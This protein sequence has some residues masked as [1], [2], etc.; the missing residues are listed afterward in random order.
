[1]CIVDSYESTKIS[2]CHQSS[3][4]HSSLIDFARRL[5]LF[6]DVQWTDRCIEACKHGYDC[7]THCHHRWIDRWFDSLLYVLCVFIGEGEFYSSGNDFSPDELAK[8]SV[9]FD[10]RTIVNCIFYIVWM[11]PIDDRYL[12][13]S[14]THSSIMR[15]RWL[16]VWMDRR[17]VSRVRRW[18][19]SNWWLH[20]IGYWVVTYSSELLF[21]S[22]ICRH[23]SQHHSLNLVCVPKAARVWRYR[24]WLDIQRFVDIHLESIAN[25]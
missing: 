2:K 6:S 19:C 18:H 4:T 14:P 21:F 20:L 15:S 11:N 24:Q 12:P 23:T 5:H 7:R 10:R 1:M 13:T 22:R 9:R 17:L 25:I 8:K 3:G 16:H